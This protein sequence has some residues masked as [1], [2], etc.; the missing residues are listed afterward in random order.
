VARRY[1]TVGEE[2]GRAPPNFVQEG[3]EEGARQQAAV[4][5]EIEARK[6]RT[7]DDHPGAAPGTQVPRAGTKLRVQLAP[8]VDGR[9]LHPVGDA[10]IF[11]GGLALLTLTDTEAGRIAAELLGEDCLDAVIW[12][13]KPT[14]RLR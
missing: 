3:L 1:L 14:L 7:D 8:N 2:F 13:S 4:R 5:A 9:S 6:R 11:E 12:G 10:E